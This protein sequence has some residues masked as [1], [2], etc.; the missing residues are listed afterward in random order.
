MGNP[1]GDIEPVQAPPPWTC[2]HF[3][4]TLGSDEVPEV[5]RRVAA[6]VE[7]IERFQ[8]LNLVVTLCDE[9]ATASVYYWRM[10]DAGSPAT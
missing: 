7:K 5:L 10:D 6:A 2:D 8:L 3:A 1:G 9:E 4:L